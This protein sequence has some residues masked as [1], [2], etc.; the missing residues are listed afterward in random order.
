MVQFRE[1][2]EFALYD[3]KQGYYNTHLQ[4]IPD[5]VTAPNFGPYLG[6]G[7]ARQLAKAW[8]L[9]PHLISPKV[10]TFV[11]AGCGSQAYLTRSVLST[12]QAEEPHL[13]SKVQVILVDR[14]ASRLAQAVSSLSPLYPG[15]VFGCPDIAQIPKM[16]GAVVSNELLDAFPVRPIRKSDGDCVEEAFVEKDGKGRFHFSW[17]PCQDPVVISFGL[18]LPL[19]D[20]CY[21]FNGEALRYLEI[22]SDRLEHGLVM[23]IDYGDTR[24][25]LFARS[26]VK[27]F[28]QGEVKVPNLNNPGFEDIT[29]PVDFTLMM[30][31]GSRVGLD[32][33]YYETLGGFLIQSGVADF[34]QEPNTRE[35]IEENMRLKTLIHPHGFGEDFKVLLQ[36]K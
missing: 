23:T 36:G 18:E 2:M 32:T 8:S 27:A 22:V 21:A 9:A 5:Y 30:D 34:L 24:P 14:S 31:W 19:E 28:S 12:W 26:P 15:K 6:C 13:F 16:W 11:E 29:S 4:S 25:T 35:A 1:W 33:L 3:R 10:F 7:I 17:R 20:V